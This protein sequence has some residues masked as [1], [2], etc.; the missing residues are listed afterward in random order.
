M[1][2]AT[3]RAERLCDC[4]GNQI[5]T[6]LVGLDA[7]RKFLVR[8]R[9]RN[10][11]YAHAAPHSRRPDKVPRE[12]NPPAV[13]YT[14][15]SGPSKTSARRMIPVRRKENAQKSGAASWSRYVVVRLAPAS[16]VIASI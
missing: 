13:N 15:Q 9:A 6:L 2:A 11:Q 5:E 12:K 7:G 1:V 14:D 16:R 3:V 8:D 10:H 4:F